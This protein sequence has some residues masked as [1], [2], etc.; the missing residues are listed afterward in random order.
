MSPAPRSAAEPAAEPCGFSL[1]ILTHFSPFHHLS[2]AVSQQDYGLQLAPASCSSEASRMPS[3]TPTKGNPSC[4]YSFLDFLLLLDWSQDVITPPR[5]TDSGGQPVS[6]SPHPLCFLQAEMPLGPTAAAGNLLAAS[7]CPT[8]DQL[9]MGHQVQVPKWRCSLRCV[10]CSLAGQHL[11]PEQRQEPTP[12]TVPAAK[13][14]FL[15]MHS[16]HFSALKDPGW[17]LISCWNITPLLILSHCIAMTSPNLC[18]SSA[19]ASSLSRGL[20]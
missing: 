11:S 7:A 6:L 17:Y 20:Q 16:S 13:L 19:G 3:P 5:N 8:L 18:F 10:C 2:L 9:H 12:A 15:E 1:H 14:S 4:P